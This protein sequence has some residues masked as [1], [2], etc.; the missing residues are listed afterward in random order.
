MLGDVPLDSTNHLVTALTKEGIIQ[1][2]YD[3]DG[4]RVLTKVQ[5]NGKVVKHTQYLVDVESSYRDLLYATD[6][7]LG[8]TRLFIYGEGVDPYRATRRILLLSEG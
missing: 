7:L 5:K 8:T 3:G 4:N 6:S 2:Q 1:Y